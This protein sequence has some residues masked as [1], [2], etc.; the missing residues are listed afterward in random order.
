MTIELY[1]GFV[2]SGKS[3]CATKLGVN[4]VDAP[5]SRRY[6]IANFPIRPKKRKL[7]FLYKGE[8]KY[9]PLDRWIYKPNEELT[10][11]FLVKKS[12]EMGWNKKESSCL[13]IFDEASIPFNARTYQRRDRLDWIKF[14]SQ[15]RKFGYDV[16]FIT[17][18]ARMLDK[19]I[20]SLCEFEIVHKKLNNMFALSWLSLL[21]LTIFAQVKYWNGTNA[22][23]TRGQ[24]RL[25]RY[26]KKVAQRYD[27]LRLFDMEEKKNA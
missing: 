26:S 11:D 24:L 22:R 6:V 21:R 18:D 27:S 23:Y 13:I 12:L 20:R 3:F 15:S 19:Q 5:F 10:V 7:H 14:L 2:G 8:N 1:T 9:K 4:I 17:Q 25:V 16:I